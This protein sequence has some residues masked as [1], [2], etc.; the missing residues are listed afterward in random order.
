MNTSP[1]C[2]E[3]LCHF[4]QI[5]EVQVKS[6]VILCLLRLNYGNVVGHKAEN[7]SCHIHMILID[8]SDCLKCTVPY[9]IYV[10]Q[11]KKPISF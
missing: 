5:H 2:S 4:K 3:S 7:Y 11:K 8:R 1:R 6:E 10:C 9:L